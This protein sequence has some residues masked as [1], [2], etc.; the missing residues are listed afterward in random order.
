[1]LALLIVILQMIRK[2][3][4]DRAEFIENYVSKFFIDKTLNTAFHDLVYTYDDDT[5]KQFE[6]IRI[7]QELDK[8][9]KGKRPIFE[10]FSEFQAER[11]IGSRLYHPK[12]FQGSSEE[13][14]LD[15]L[16][17]YF[18]VIAHRY[19]KG[20]LRLDDISGNIGYCLLVMH[21]RM[22]IQEYLN[23]QESN[24]KKGGYQKFGR[25]PPL[26]QL[27]ELMNDM[28]ERNKPAE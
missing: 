18:N 27:R 19:T 17:G 14:R 9:D 23:Y 10:P 7:K 22:V 1:M 16:L 8:P 20:L 24:W 13:M 4:L 2:L 25:S 6:C 28:Y 26:T 3:M 12:L 15:A 21:K 5:F 11:E